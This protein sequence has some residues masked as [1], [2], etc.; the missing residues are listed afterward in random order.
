MST[1]QY[2][3]VAL[4]LA[5]ATDITFAA[6]VYCD[7]QNSVH[8]AKIWVGWKSFLRGSRANPF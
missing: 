2:T 8:Y 4:I 5:V 6:G 3:P 1:F 7:T